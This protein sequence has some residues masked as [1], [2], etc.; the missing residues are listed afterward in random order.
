M[1]AASKSHRPRHHAR[2]RGKGSTVTR[3]APPVQAGPAEHD[4]SEREHC[5]LLDHPPALRK[6]SEAASLLSLLDSLPTARRENE[7]GEG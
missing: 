5:A 4:D 3:S 6:G 2:P 1:K 7:G